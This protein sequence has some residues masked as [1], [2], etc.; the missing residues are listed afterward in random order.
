MKKIKPATYKLSKTPYLV[1]SLD[2]STGHLTKQD[3]KLLRAAA[4]GVDTNPIIA[5]KYE[6]GYFVHVPDKDEGLNKACIKEGYS[7]EFT[8]LL[9]RARELGCKYIQFDGDGITYDDIPSFD[10]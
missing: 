2:I 1:K 10:W 4:K 5:Y 7:K 6:Y 9:I 8:L 3:E